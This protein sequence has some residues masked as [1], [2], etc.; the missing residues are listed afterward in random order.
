MLSFYFNNIFLLSAIRVFMLT[1]CI[2]SAIGVA[3]AD[4]ASR[5]DFETVLSRDSM[6][7]FNVRWLG[8]DTLLLSMKNEDGAVTVTL[9]GVLSKTAYEGS[10]I[11]ASP[12][13]KSFIQRLEGGW[14]LFNQ[15]TEEKLFFADPG[16]SRD[17][18]AYR[19]PVWSAD[20]R[21][22]AIA[23]RYRPV[24]STKREPQLIDGANVIVLDDADAHSSRMITRLTVIDGEEPETV[25]RYF[26][27][28]VAVNLEWGPDGDLYATRMAFSAAPPF[29]AILRLA[30]GA[31]GFSEIYRTPGRFQSMI[32]AVSPDGKFIAGVLNFETRKWEEFQSLFLIDIETGAE[33]KRLTYDLPV[34]GGDYH[35]S[36]DGSEI[37][38][39]VGTGGLDQIWAISL[40]G[41][42][43]K[44]TD[45]LRRHFD[46][47]LSP[48]GNRLSYQTEDGYGRKDVRVYNLGTGEE[49]IVYVTDDPSTAHRL[50]EWRHIRW[51]STDGVKPY[52]YLFLPPDFSPNK[53]YPLYVDIH[54]GGPGSRLYLSA[55]LNAGVQRG[56]LGWHALAAK[57]YVV[58]VPD[59]RSTGDY[60]PEAILRPRRKGKMPAL[61]DV[62]DAVSGVRHLIKQG[63]VDPRRV[64]LFGHSAGGRRAFLALMQHGDLFAAGILND[65][66]AP[67]RTSSFIN[68]MSGRYTGGQTAGFTADN[69]GG[70][71]S[72][73]PARYKANYLFDA[74]KIRTP[75]LIMM[76]NEE[77]GSVEH[78]PYETAYSILKSQGAPTK[79]ILFPE[80]GHVYAMPESARFAF[81][82]VLDWLE[83]YMPPAEAD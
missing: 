33:I 44:L 73:V 15:E 40:E 28:D 81:D 26:I 12:D 34:K 38:A 10:L 55:P 19:L 22:V 9:D 53:K 1:I 58:F 80:E 72:E 24:G 60:G 77:K 39:R 27:D 21:R 76:G 74:Y 17:F 32:P 69:F 23:E 49:R 42:P 52:G 6:S 18:S 68:L 63:F 51:K 50:G 30:P 7:D 62:E 13:G 5:I 71:L 3:R 43:R 65:P 54:G 59:Y 66:I 14:E 75:T 25:R 82:E 31:D 8:D 47:D 41:E 11:S 20:G 37:Y 2:T 56:P 45:G 36:R 67:D 83:T 46:I 64:A 16:D 4:S 61:D 29:T 48:D 79:M 57:G 78:W 70:S 35:W